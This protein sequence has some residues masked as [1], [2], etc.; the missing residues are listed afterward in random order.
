MNKKL[1]DVYFYIKIPTLLTMSLI[2]SFD[3]DFYKR[4][5]HET[6]SPF[7]NVL[8]SNVGNLCKGININTK[9]KI[10]ELTHIIYGQYHPEIQIIL[11]LLIN[12]EFLYVCPVIN[13]DKINLDSFPKLKTLFLSFEHITNKN[14]RNLS[15][16]IETLYF[17]VSY[18]S[19]SEIDDKIFVFDNLPLNLKKI[20]F[21][22]G[23]KGK[24]NYARTRI[25][26][27]NKIK[28]YKI[29]FGCKIYFFTGDINS[30]IEESL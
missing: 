6:N 27:L 17:D 19:K 1:F 18:Y 12:L 25:I 7:F 23:I 4:N 9:I 28:K 10:E 22:C 5:T 15:N 2:N 20:I 24:K 29:P 3:Y 16:N 21:N 8:I 14:L 11:D 13:L 26:I 30:F